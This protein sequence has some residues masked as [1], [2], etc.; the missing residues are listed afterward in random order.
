M[1]IV[2]VSY[3]LRNYGNPAR[4]IRRSCS[5][6]AEVYNTHIVLVLMFNSFSPSPPPTLSLSSSPVAETFLCKQ[7]CSF[8]CLFSLSYFPWWRDYTKLWLS[9]WQMVSKYSP[10][11]TCMSSSTLYYSDYT[12]ECACDQKNSCL[13]SSPKPLVSRT[14]GKR[15]QKGGD[16]FQD[17]DTNQ[18]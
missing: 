12:V 13:L 15:G 5:P 16:I 6:N 3:S 18:R 17:E 10:I 8:W 11:S 14:K 7:W 4:F 2:I 9:L 1:F